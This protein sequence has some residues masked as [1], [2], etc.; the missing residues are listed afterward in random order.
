MAIVLTKYKNKKGQDVPYLYTDQ[1]G[2][3]WVRKRMGDYTP[4]KKLDTDVESIAIKKIYA[5][6]KELEDQHE[7]KT[8]SGDENAA[9]KK[10]VKIFADYYADVMKKKKVDGVRVTTYRRIEILK[11][12]SLEP[13][14]FWLLKPDEIRKEHGI[15]FKLWHL[16]TRI[17]KR[18]GKPIQLV[19]TMKILGEILRAMVSDGTLQAKNMPDI[20]LPLS[21]KRHHAQNKGRAISLEEFNK[22]AEHYDP[23][24]QLMARL[25]YDL[26][27]RKMELGSLLCER[28]RKIEGRVFIDLSHEDTKTGMPR[29]IPVPIDLADELWKRKNKNK[30]Y[31]FESIKDEDKHIAAG[32]IDQHWTAAK[33]AAGVVGRLR[34]HDLRDSAATNMVKADINPILICTIL[35]MS[36]QMLQKKY[37]QL[38]PEDLLK[39][40]ETMV[41]S[42]GGASD[43]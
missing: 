34:F 16:K 36:M 43:E 1:N 37:L 35:G 41:K 24:Y 15:E 32:V 17:N 2:Y 3:F 26:G 9:D 5:A 14:M 6:I 22:I 42:R 10:N 33:D 25:A 27:N 19:N 30:T 40:I 38:K 31:V 8:K 7:Q 21:E 29:I 20:D 28:V 11:K 23:R 12:Y 13:S 39:A 4:R 18:T